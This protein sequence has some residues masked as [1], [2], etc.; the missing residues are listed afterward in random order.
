MR[1]G[2]PRRSRDIFAALGIAQADAEVVA[3]DL[4]L[5]DLEGIGSHGVMLVP[6]YVDRILQ[7]LGVEAQPGDVVSDIRTAIVI[8]AGNA[9]GQLTAHQAVKLAVGAREEFGHGDRRACATPSIS[10]PPAAMRG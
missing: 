1:S 4:V 3:N 9:L 2:W 6:M 5:A 8:D 10:A 7:G